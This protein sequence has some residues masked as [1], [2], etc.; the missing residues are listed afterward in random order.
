[1]P[2]KRKKLFGTKKRTPTDNADEIPP[3]ERFYPA[4]DIP[5]DLRL[6]ATIYVWN[7]PSRSRPQPLRFGFAQEGELLQFSR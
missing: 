2:P 4:P 7:Y 1:M 6:P 3:G 5:M